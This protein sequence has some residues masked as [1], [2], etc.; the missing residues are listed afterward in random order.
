MNGQLETDHMLV[1]TVTVPTTDAA[2]LA[3]SVREGVIRVLGPDG[4]RHEVPLPAGADADR[5]QAGL[6][7]DILE[8]R[9]P[10][11]PAAAKRPQRDVLVRRLR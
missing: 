2:Q 9:A 10:R 8:L 6:F 11:A 4:F 3:V 5:L 7:Q 1:V